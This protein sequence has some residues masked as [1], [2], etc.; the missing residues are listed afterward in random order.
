M[1]SQ[2]LQLVNYEQAKRLKKAGYIWNAFA[3]NNWYEPMDKKLNHG[4]LYPLEYYAAP[5]VALA[6]KWIRDEKK[7]SNAV[8]FF[9]VTSPR[10]IGRYQV[11]RITDVLDKRLCPRNVYETEYFD[12]YELAESAL[13]DALLDILESDNGKNV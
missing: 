7:I 11:S 12:T 2:E 8:S 9:D 3:H 4:N 10:Y 5:T 13:L 1:N 6:L